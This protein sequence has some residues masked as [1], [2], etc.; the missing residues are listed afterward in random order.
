MYNPEINTRSAGL[1][2]KTRL[3][4]QTVFVTSPYD[5]HNKPIFLPKQQAG[6]L[7]NGAYYLGCM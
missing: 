6:C 1:T 4:G 5:G 2:L 7:L 3:L